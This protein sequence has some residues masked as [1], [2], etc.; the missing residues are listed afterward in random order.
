[1]TMD[2][3]FGA[4]T[5]KA[6]PRGRGVAA[7][8]AVHQRGSRAAKA[9]TRGR[10][11]GTGERVAREPLAGRVAARMVPSGGE[12]TGRR[13]RDPDPGTGPARPS[14]RL[15]WPAAMPQPLGDEL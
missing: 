4:I 9:R 11:G 12:R 2:T 6:P 13:A 8:C 14:R 10:A 1:M 5:L 7:E 3:S 15:R